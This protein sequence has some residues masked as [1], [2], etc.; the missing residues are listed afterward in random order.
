V[1]GKIALIDR[2]SCNFTV[3]VKYAQNAGALAV[4]IADN[5]EGSP[6]P[7]LGGTDAS[8]TIPAVRV[9]QDDGAKLRANLPAT[10]NLGLDDA[11]LSGADDAGKLLLY[12]PSPFEP[13][14]S[15]SHFDTSATPNLLME[16]IINGDLTH[17][18]DATLET[19]RDIGWFRG[20]PVGGGPTTWFL[21]SSAHASGA[22]GAFYTTDVTVSN[23]GSSAASFT[24]KF[25]GHDQDG[26][27]GAEKT[28]T[29]GAGKTATYADVLGSMF[30]VT[31]G[32]G[33][34]RISSDSATLKIVSQTS[35]PGSG[36]SFGQSV[37]LASGSDL[38]AAGAPKA[39]G[40]AREDASFR[41]NLVLVNT[42]EASLDVDVTVLGDDGTNLGV[43]HFTGFQPL[44]MRQISRVL[45][46]ITGSSSLKNATLVLSTPTAGGAFAAYASVIDNVTND[47]RTL[48]ASGV[49]TATTWFLPSSA[50]ASGANG[51]FY[52]TDVTLA[53]R[54]ASLASFTLKFLG[55]DQDGRS[56]AEKTFTLAAG[57]AVTY[58]DV[59]G[60]AF[61]VTSGFGAVRIASDS[62]SLK[63]VSQTSTP[64]AGGTFGQSVPLANGTDLISAG[65]PKTIGAAREDASF[66]TNLVLVNT[67]EGPLDIDVTVLGDDGSMLGTG[68]YT[69]FSP[70]EMRQI[71]RVLQ[72]I[73]GSSNLK[74]ATLVL[75]TP[76]TGGSFAA[77][78]SIID[79]A[80]ND[81]RT[82]LP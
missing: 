25:L 17:G 6:P 60:S 9:T 37:P 69:G 64:G 36:G 1:A 35:T 19:F 61:A 26:R 15:V 48:L 52:T 30:G 75:S 7:G 78:A 3:K 11:L 72:A 24:L 79:N 27:T 41:T 5:A 67:T 46:T 16:P 57:K 13:G 23:R 59:L 14:S 58:A 77:Y 62:A 10:V 43:G 44:E 28:F 49:G 2:G 80:T 40:A 18:V 71:S 65:A 73:T 21:A 74:N 8:I 82:L 70:L 4:I 20:D 68:H 51:A 50:H 38:V 39:I 47:P 66:R 34:V 12:A 31:S 53:N 81:P 22:N 55:H 33:A 63:I 32:F 76:T 42:T 56:G 54:G 29:L 45:Q